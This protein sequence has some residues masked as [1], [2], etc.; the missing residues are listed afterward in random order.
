LSFRPEG[1][2]FDSDYISQSLRFFEMTF[3]NFSEVSSIIIKRFYLNVAKAH[4]I[5]VFIIAVG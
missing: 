4:N 1:E 5:L 2:I 3:L